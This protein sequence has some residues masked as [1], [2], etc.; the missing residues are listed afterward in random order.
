MANKITLNNTFKAID[1][2]GELNKMESNLM[3]RIAELKET[4]EKTKEINPPNKG[5]SIKHMKNIIGNMK[6]QLKILRKYK[7][8]KEEDT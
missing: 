7:K 8:K 4:I 5:E 2:H 6:R 1:D 3:K